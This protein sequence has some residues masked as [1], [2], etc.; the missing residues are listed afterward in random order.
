MDYKHLVMP[1]Q[2]GGL[3]FRVFKHYYYSADNARAL[4]QFRFPKTRTTYFCPLSLKL[5]PMSLVKPYAPMSFSLFT[6]RVSAS[7]SASHSLVVRRIF[8]VGRF[9]LTSCILNTP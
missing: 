9:S 1:T 7:E 5:E 2:H 4:A 3:G 6:N 8:V